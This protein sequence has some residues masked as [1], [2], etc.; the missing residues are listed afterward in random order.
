MLTDVFLQD[1]IDR[2]APL[3]LPLVE[4]IVENTTLLWR[5]ILKDRR[6]GLWTALAL[7]FQRVEDGQNTEKGKEQQLGRLGRM[8]LRMIE[9]EWTRL[10]PAA[11]RRD[12]DLVERDLEVLALLLTLLDRLRLIGLPARPLLRQRFFCQIIH[13]AATNAR[14][15]SRRLLPFLKLVKAVSTFQPSL[16]P[17]LPISEREALISLIVLA[18]E[19][20]TSEMDQVANVD[21]A[22]LLH[23]LKGSDPARPSGF[24]SKMLLPLFTAKLDAAATTN[25]RNRTARSS[26][27]SDL[28]ASPVVTPA[29]RQHLSRLLAPFKR[30][31]S[32]R[33]SPQVGPPSKLPGPAEPKE[34]VTT[35]TR[36]QSPSGMLTSNVD[37]FTL[38]LSP[39]LFSASITSFPSSANANPPLPGPMDIFAIPE[40]A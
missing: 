37:T 5:V 13:E 38:P 4:R 11:G 14:G 2:G 8:M 34:P 24:L 10:H 35:S 39:L 16:L 12:P 3:D 40:E 18:L 30:A 28:T 29:P 22:K 21:M 31:R 32:S 33:L 9:A 17:S 25:F 1:K 6:V 36:Q 19:H 20:E 27:P 26:L 7:F 15:S 23:T